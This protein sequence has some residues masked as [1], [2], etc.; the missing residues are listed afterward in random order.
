VQ[1]AARK[2][3]KEAAPAPAAVRTLI[4]AAEMLAQQQAAAAAA[5]EAEKRAEDRQDN[6]KFDAD[7]VFAKLKDVKIEQPGE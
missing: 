7:S 5:A 1:K 3:G 4:P 2:A 6:K